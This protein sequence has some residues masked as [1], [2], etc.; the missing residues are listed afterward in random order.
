[1]KR[2][3]MKEREEEYKERYDKEEGRRYD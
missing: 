3:V 1:M 2:D